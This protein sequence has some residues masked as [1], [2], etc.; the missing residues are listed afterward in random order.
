M[1]EPNEGADNASDGTLDEIKTEVDAANEV[2]FFYFCQ[3]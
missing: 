2:M 3:C 1:S